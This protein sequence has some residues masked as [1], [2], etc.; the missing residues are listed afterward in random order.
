MQYTKPMIELVFEIRRRVPSDMKPS[1]KLANPE[2][3]QE[4]ATYHRASRDVVTKALTKELMYLAG[5]PWPDRLESKS[6]D[7]PPKQITKVY[8]GQVTLVEAPSPDKAKKAHPNRVYR[9]QIM[10]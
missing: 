6:A 2:L 1:V 3:L 9:G 7:T 10:D 5:A 8:R 4:L